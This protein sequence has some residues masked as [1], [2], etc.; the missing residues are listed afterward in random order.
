M[1]PLTSV[2]EDLA[3]TEDCKAANAPNT[4]QRVETPSKA[5]KP[6]DRCMSVE[7][8]GRVGEKVQVGN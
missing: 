1:D 5:R 6:N 7:L 3:V 8:H 4:K 2:K